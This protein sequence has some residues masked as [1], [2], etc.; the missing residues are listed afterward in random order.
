[1][2]RSMIESHGGKLSI[3]RRSAGN[4]VFSFSLPLADPKEGPP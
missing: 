4:T 2:S 1:M 3:E